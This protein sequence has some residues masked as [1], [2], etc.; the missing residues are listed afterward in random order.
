MH[1]RNQSHRS[2]HRGYSIKNGI[3]KNFTILKGKHV[4]WSLFLRKLQVFIKRRIQLRCFPV[5]IAK[6]LRTPCIFKNI[7]EGL[8]PTL[9]TLQML[10][11]IHLWILQKC[12]ETGFQQNCYEQLLRANALNYFYSYLLFSVA[13]WNTHFFISSQFI[14]NQYWT[15]KVIICFQYSKLKYNKQPLRNRNKKKQK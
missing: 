11:A 13:R 14:S 8:L 12:S 15:A 5:N 9:L 7:C 3:F 2:S 6:V 4:S 1:S 10:W